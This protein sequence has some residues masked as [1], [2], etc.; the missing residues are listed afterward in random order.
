MTERRRLEAKEESPFFP[1][2]DERPPWLQQY[3]KN[4][5]NY[6]YVLIFNS[7][8][9]ERYDDGLDYL[10]ALTE[11]LFDSPLVTQVTLYDDNY[12]SGAAA[13]ERYAT[14]AQY[15]GRIVRARE[16]GKLDWMIYLRFTAVDYD[17][18]RAEVQAHVD[19][20]FADHALPDHIEKVNAIYHIENH[21]VVRHE[22]YEPIGAA[23]GIGTE[24]TPGTNKC[25]N[26]GFSK[27][28][29]DPLR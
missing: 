1:A 13:R 29:R 22:E 8:D 28:S 27:P 2:G 18:V 26:Y 23:A 24:G 7:R 3:I 11:S 9:L 14:L 20:C 16:S 5:H 21:V 6:V 19:R 10:A 25:A 17:A 12:G 4:R 15:Q